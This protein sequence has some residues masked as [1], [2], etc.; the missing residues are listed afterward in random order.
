MIIIGE[1]INGAIPR[2]AAAI[3]E[4]DAEYVSD[5]VRAQEA[6][7]ADYL[8]VCAGTDPSEEYAAL[9]WLIDVVQSVATKPLCLDSPDPHILERV[10][11]R[12]KQP[13]ILNSISGEGQKCAILLPLL[14]D[15]GGWQAVALCCDNDGMAATSDDKLRIASW[16]IEEADRYGVGP[17]RLHIDPLVLALSA[18]NDAALQFTTAIQRIHELSPQVQ[19]AAAISNV[20]YG[21]PARGLVN[22]NFLTMAIVAGLNTAIVDPTNRDII[23]NIYATEALVNQDK[24]CRK[25]NNAYRAGRIGQAR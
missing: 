19:V 23:G 9:C 11:E 2:T 8:D 24:F 20:S 13:G 14:R 1:K 25:Y 7:G 16:L 17:E 6:S 15:A 10:M 12:V 21:M 18:V 22:R 3:R 5:L 4:R